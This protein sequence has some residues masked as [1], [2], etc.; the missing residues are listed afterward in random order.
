VTRPFRQSLLSGDVW[1]LAAANCSFGLTSLYLSFY[2]Y[3]CIY[4]CD[5]PI[6]AIASRR[7][8]MVPGLT[9]I[10][11]V[12]DPAFVITFPLS[13]DVWSL[14]AAD[15]SLLL[16]AKLTPRTCLLSL[17]IYLYIYLHMYL[18]NTPV[19]AIPSQAPF[20]FFFFR[21]RLVPSRSRPLASTTRKTHP[22]HVPPRRTHRKRRPRKIRGWGRAPGRGR[23][24]GRA[25]GRGPGTD[26]G[27]RLGAASTQRRARGWGRRGMCQIHSYVFIC[28]C[29]HF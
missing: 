17:Y 3:L 24:P 11:F 21:R 22:A 4:L 1:S 19:S 27:V 6:S 29:V 23:G 25:P 7:R 16:R 12:T 26:R 14:A 2:I 20:F 9:R 8:R 28:V 10:P 13:G 18:C 5:T 15:R